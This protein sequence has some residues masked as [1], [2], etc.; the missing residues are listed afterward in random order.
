MSGIDERTAVRLIAEYDRLVHLIASDFPTFDRDDLVAAGRIGLMEAHLT[1]DPTR[2]PQKQWVAKVVRW[3]II[4]VVDREIAQSQTELL[5]GLDDPEPMTNGQHD[6]ERA[7][8]KSVALRAFGRLAPREQ[9][10]LDARFRGYT[11]E[12][13]GASLGISRSLTHQV[14]KKALGEL[15]AWANGQTRPGQIIEFSP[16]RSRT[17]G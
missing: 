6:P 13:I 17:M 5:T 9:V 16:R 14:A 10:I 1:H 8:L 2:S 7:H 15:R 11:Y 3:R 4:G 12:E